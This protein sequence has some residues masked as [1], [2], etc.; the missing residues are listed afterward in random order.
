MKHQSIIEI[1]LQTLN[2]YVLRF[3]SAID[4]LHQRLQKKRLTIKWEKIQFPC[5]GFYRF[6]TRTKSQICG[7]FFF[8][9]FISKPMSLRFWL[10]PP[11]RL[12]FKVRSSRVMC[13]H[14]A[15]SLISL[16]S[17][18]II[19]IIKI[20]LI[21]LPLRGAASDIIPFLHC[22]VEC[23]SEKKKKKNASWVTSTPCLF[24]TVKITFFCL[25]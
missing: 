2:H 17:L 16:P 10:M 12:C 6:V 24:R 19:A 14:C 3:Q 13:A 4:P 25:D 21:L 9:P 7:G 23:K 11:V 5:T 22:A 8:S 18:V 1:F 20:S 15:E